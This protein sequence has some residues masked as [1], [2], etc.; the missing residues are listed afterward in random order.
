MQIQNATA[1]RWNTLVVYAGGSELAIE[2]S[3]DRQ[4][5]RQTD[6]DRQTERE[7]VSDNFI[8]QRA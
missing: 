5:D 7:L 1:N 3:R 6:R 2:R 8:L 4:T